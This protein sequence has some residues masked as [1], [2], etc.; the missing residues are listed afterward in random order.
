MPTK[1]TVNLPDETVG[2]LKSI[3]EARGTTVTEA[4]RQV[5]ESQRFLDGEVQK[6]NDLL[7]QNP[8]DKSVRQVVFN[9]P[10]K[11]SSR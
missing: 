7:I 1:V 5:I 10:P 8:R 3:A 2:A 9:T 6:G 11:S 4:L